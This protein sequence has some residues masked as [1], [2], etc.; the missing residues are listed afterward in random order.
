MIGFGVQRRTRGMT[1]T[2]KFGSLLLLLTAGSLAGTLTF[3]IFFSDTAGDGLY[4]VAAHIEQGTLAQLQIQT[5][6]V[7]DGQEEARNP[8]QRLIE[9]YDMLITTMEDGGL[10]PV[11]PLTLLGRVLG[12]S[13]DLA[14]EPV[15]RELHEGLPKPPEDLKQR[16]EPVYQLW[17]E[18]AGPLRTIAQKP[19]DDPDAKAAYDL[20]RPKL[21][22][23]DQASRLIMVAVAAR[24]VE[25]RQRILIIL[26][27]IAGLSV[28]LFFVGLW[29]TKR[30]IL[31]PIELI[32]TTAR[33]IRAGDFSKRV[34][35]VSSDEIASLAMTIN[36]MCSEVEH[37]VEQYREL[38]ENAS[39]IVYTMSLN[40]N[41]LSVNRAGERITGYP[42]EEF[43]KMN[44]EE[45]LPP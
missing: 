7:R 37:S 31:H 29:F 35:I 10:H 45:L 28:T 16:I 24:I 33:Q 9:A 6:R 14:Q 18:I 43:L 17:H 23:I 11:R 25:A 42:R 20:I 1:L 40:G 32:E 22:E 2:K 36:D 3:A 27:S 30:Y 5:L 41:F 21:V 12:G 19:H 39:D 15:I 34:P 13:S 4:L 44:V 26:A 8:Q 38:F